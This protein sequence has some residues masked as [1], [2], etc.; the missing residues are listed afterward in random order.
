MRR[1]TLPLVLGL[2]HGVA[3]GVALG[4]VVVPRFL[5][6]PSGRGDGLPVRYGAGST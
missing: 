6:G 4:L 2:A 1:L 3:D 5:I